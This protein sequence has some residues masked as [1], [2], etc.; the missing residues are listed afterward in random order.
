MVLSSVEPTPDGW[1]RS[2]A[3]NRLD[4]SEKS[5]VSYF[6]GMVQADVM[7]KAKLGVSHLVH[8]D[9]LL[10]WI[11]Q[12][13]RAKR[14]DLVG[15]NF[16]GSGRVLLEAKGRTHGFNRTTANHAR[17]QVKDPPP[18]V[19]T[20]VGSNSLRVVSFAYFESTTK[21]G[22]VVWKSY[23][24]DPPGQSGEEPDIPDSEFRA[25]VD[26]AYFL[27]LAKSISALETDE[28]SR[29]KKSAENG[30]IEADLPDLD[31][32]VTMPLDIYETLKEAPAVLD[33]LS[34]REFSEVLD[35]PFVKPAWAMGLEDEAT[36]DRAVWATEDGVVINVPSDPDER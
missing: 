36:A 27:P 8:I 5:A 35:R 2:S 11:Q 31:V 6:L 9:P 4:G 12:P 29:V 24:E 21:G 20:L 13:T 33:R 17:D 3:Y 19:L 30:F 26:T 10:Y 25:L 28:R 34:V 18:Q 16:S 23:L 22:P 14:P 15:Y 1:R 32:K 7:A